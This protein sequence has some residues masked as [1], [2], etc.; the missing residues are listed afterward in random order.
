[1][2]T[3]PT[4]SSRSSAF[5][6]PLNLGTM[7]DVNRLEARRCKLP[8]EGGTPTAAMAAATPGSCHACLSAHEDHADVSTWWSNLAKEIEQISVWI[9]KIDRPVAPGHGRGRDDELDLQVSKALKS[10]VF[11]VHIWHLKL[12]HDRAR[13]DVGQRSC[14]GDVDVC[15]DGPESEAGIPSWKLGVRSVPLRVCLK[16][17]AVKGGKALDVVRQSDGVGECG[18]G[19]VVE[20][21]LAAAG[22]LRDTLAWTRMRDVDQRVC[23]AHAQRSG[24]RAGR[25]VAPPDQWCLSRTDHIDRLFALRATWC[26]GP[27]KPSS[28]GLRGEEATSVEYDLAGE[29]GRFDLNPSEL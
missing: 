27:S 28:Q 1:M 6:P 17:R 21:L 20:S 11:R 12:E 7:V 3:T 23:S 9:P 13:A 24:S 18:H 26:L 8:A 29:S 16:D 4:T 22:V 14:A 15:T 25:R 5:L 19:S 2:R 10:P